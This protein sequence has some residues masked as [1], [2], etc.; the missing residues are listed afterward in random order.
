MTTA[1][2]S[3]PPTLAW[4]VSIPML[5]YFSP[6]DERLASKIERL[7]IRSRAILLADRDP[8]C[9]PKELD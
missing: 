4:G 2:W 6:G 3:R 9:F 7:A 8:I 1:S 5:P